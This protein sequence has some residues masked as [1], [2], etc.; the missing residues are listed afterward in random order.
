MRTEIFEIKKKDQNKRSDTSEVLFALN[1]T[2]SLNE[3]LM[4]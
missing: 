1:M 2:C 4:C 3:Y